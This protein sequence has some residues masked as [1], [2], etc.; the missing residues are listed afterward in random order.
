MNMELGEVNTAEYRYQVKA[1]LK[2]IEKRRKS[3]GGTQKKVQFREIY[4]ADST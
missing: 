1:K 2:S 3:K 4:E